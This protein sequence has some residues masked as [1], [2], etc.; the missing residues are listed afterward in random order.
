MFV[1]K[2]NAF[3]VHAFY[4]AHLWSIQTLACTNCLVGIHPNLSINTDLFIIHCWIEYDKNA[5]EKLLKTY[6]KTRD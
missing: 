5:L 4:R 6:P 2:Q 1:E 3:L